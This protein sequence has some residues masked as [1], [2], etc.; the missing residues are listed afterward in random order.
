MDLLAT[1]MDKN[2]SSAFQPTVRQ[3]DAHRTELETRIARDGVRYTKEG[4]LQYYGRQC[5]E[6]LWQ[7]ADVL[8]AQ[9]QSVA[10]SSGIMQR[11]LP[12]RVAHES[13]DSQAEKQI[14]LSDSSALFDAEAAFAY[15]PERRGPIGRATA[16]E[17]LKCL[18]RTSRVVNEVDLTDNDMLDWRGY[19]ANHPRKLEIIGPGVVRFLWVRFPNIVDPNIGLRCDFVV[20]RADGSAVRLHPHPNKE[21]PPVYGVL[22]RWR[23]DA[24]APG[25]LDAVSESGAIE[26]NGGAAQPAGRPPVVL[27]KHCHLA[28]IP[29]IDYLSKKNARNWLDGVSVQRYYQ[30]DQAEFQWWRFIASL[31]SHQIPFCREHGIIDFGVGGDTDKHFIFYFA[32]GARIHVWPSHK[33]HWE[34]MDNP[35]DN[36][37]NTA[38]GN[39]DI[40]DGVTPG[41]WCGA[42]WVDMESPPEVN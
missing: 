23:A 31:T 8:Q 15:K 2:L 10:Q 36:S 37:G 35:L 34:I 22:A 26:V 21:D 28:G 39:A 40:I 20:A 3:T 14:V 12:P 38:G 24:P 29:Q 27:L 16:N 5:G 19:L 33:L 25:W 32:D 9:P 18:V 13:L 17:V 11:T 6:R 41:T 1:I 30:R 7:E 42:G 4:F